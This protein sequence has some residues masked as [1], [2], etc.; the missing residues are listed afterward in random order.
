[1]DVGSWLGNKKK[2]SH[3]FSIYVPAYDI[4]IEKAKIIGKELTFGW[5]N[6][7]PVSSSYKTFTEVTKHRDDAQ[8]F[9]EFI[10][11]S[12][13]IENPETVKNL[14]YE[15]IPDNPHMSIIS[16]KSS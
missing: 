3:Q 8:A 4:S 11:L 10:I 12:A 6:I 5:N 7:N 13:I 9:A 1:M 2:I 14:S 15:L 16:F